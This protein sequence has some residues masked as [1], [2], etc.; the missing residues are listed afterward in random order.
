METIFCHTCGTK[1]PINSTFCPTCGAKQLMGVTEERRIS[2]S[3]VKS[4]ESLKKPF[5]LKT[6]FIIFVIIILIGI[7]KN[8]TKEKEVWNGRQFVPQSEF[9]KEF[10]K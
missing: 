5:Y 9:N 2:D 4:E 10:G 3:K 6:W 1:F 7:F 8:L